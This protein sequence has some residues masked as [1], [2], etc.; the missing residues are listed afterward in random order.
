LKTSNNG[1]LI[2]QKS[3]T[4][5]FDENHTSLLR[6]AAAGKGNEGGGQGIK[7]PPSIKGDATSDVEAHG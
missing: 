1:S 4:P 5:F 6:I 3:A 2:K 7:S